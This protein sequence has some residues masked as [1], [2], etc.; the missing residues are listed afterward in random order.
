[1]FS[2]VCVCS[3]GGS[4]VKAGPG[5]RAAPGPGW[6]GVPGPGLGG[7]GSQVKVQ[8]RRGRPGPSGGVPS[9]GGYLVSDLGGVPSLR[10]GGGVTGLSKGKNF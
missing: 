8:G 6:G 5:R 4:Q 7:G 3:G 1:M 2:Q 10:S 9:L